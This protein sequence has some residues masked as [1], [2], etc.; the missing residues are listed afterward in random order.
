VDLN[1]G[2]VWAILFC[3]RD[4]STNQHE[5]ECGKGMKMKFIHFFNLLVGFLLIGILSAPVSAQQAS[6][7]SVPL[8]KELQV[9]V[10][11]A[12]ERGVEVVILTANPEQ[13][14][15]G[16]PQ[17][18]NKF[19]IADIR[20]RLKSSLTHIPDIP[21]ELVSVLEKSNSTGK[22][23]GFFWILA[24]TFA[25]MFI[26]LF[27]GKGSSDWASN[28][29]NLLF[30][31]ASKGRSESLLFLISLFTGKA[32]GI[33]VFGVFSLLVTLV[34]LEDNDNSQ[35]TSFVVIAV[36]SAS[37]L[38]CEFWKIWLAPKMP[39][40]R[41]FELDDDDATSMYR[42]ICTVS[43]LV[44]GLTGLNMWFSQLGFEENTLRILQVLC[45][46]GVLLLNLF[47]VWRCHRPISQLILTNAELS[48]WPKFIRF[49]ASIWSLVLGLYFSF[50][51]IVTVYRII[52]QDPEATGLSAA[53]YLAFMVAFSIY[54]VGTVV[55]DH[56]LA[57]TDDSTVLRK[58]MESEISQEDG[59]PLNEAV[60]DDEENSQKFEDLSYAGLAR[61]SLLLLI[62]GSTAAFIFVQWGV[63][64]FDEN[65]VIVSLW[66]VGLVS[67]LGF[68]AYNVVKIAINRKIIEE[69][70]DVQVAMG[71]EGGKGSVS[72]L[73][74]ILP[75]FRYAI[76]ATVLVITI[77]MILL[78]LGLDIA[79]LFAGAGVVGLAVGF[80][81]QTLVRDV[82]SGA[83]FLVD[84]AFRT[85]EYIEAGGVK[86][87]VEKISIRSM[88][89]RHH[90]GPLNTVPFG[91]IQTLTNFSRDWVM[92]KLQLRLTYDTDVEKVRKLIKKLGQELLEH[93]EVGNDFLQPLKSQGVYAM[94][95]SAMII[96]V[97]YMTKPGDQFM[98]RKLVYSKIR[99]LFEKEGIKFAHREVTVRLAEEEHS[100]DLTLEEKEAVAG[101]VLPAIEEDVNASQTDSPK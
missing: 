97:K 13:R 24:V 80:G 6:T 89:L 10:D 81:A 75:L 69:G 88:Q 17:I 45:V 5:Q 3:D 25:A 28:K 91:E 14:M 1:R 26:A 42:W 46:L 47:V 94:E 71:E 68:I 12:K 9:L 58:N 78:E 18:A 96:R 79:P 59:E 20:G 48:S 83:F 35:L 73:A 27:I 61:Q 55:I 40:Y 85:G 66:D 15:S 37:W 95:D 92:M 39:E 52:I 93:P 16:E 19:V 98:T 90:M 64:L 67:F 36:V 54:G 53:M 22:I 23:T 41:I 21:H 70:G 49:F 31:A 11:K 63:D 84:D 62:L 32:V 100:K 56:F 60:N 76:L 29:F 65:S 33:V 72:R 86:G 77:M 87:T 38:A 50:A 51:C 7:G 74:T 8:S 44:I 57:N 2:I 4:C 34:I 99:E 82:F 30:G 43:I 101:A